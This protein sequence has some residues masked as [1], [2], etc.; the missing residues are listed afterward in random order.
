MRHGLSSFVVHPG[1]QQEGCRGQRKVSAKVTMLS[2]PTGCSCWSCSPICYIM[3]IS[4][5]VDRA[6]PGQMMM[7]PEIMAST[8]FVQPTYGSVGDTRGSHPD[9][10]RHEAG[11]VDDNGFGEI[12]QDGPERR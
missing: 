2:T 9:Q 8:M 12:G 10:R 1:V 7:G 5:V 3:Y 4:V 6:G 11:A